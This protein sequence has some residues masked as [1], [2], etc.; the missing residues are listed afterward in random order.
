MLASENIIQ[1]SKA[2]VGCDTPYAC[3][4]VVHYSISCYNKII[5]NLEL[6]TISVYFS[7]LHTYI[8]AKNKNT[9][10]L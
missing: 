4:G 9:R 2:L 10:I 3:I 1:K 5:I 8:I 7:G 6:T